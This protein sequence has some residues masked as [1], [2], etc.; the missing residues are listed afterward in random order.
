MAVIFRHRQQKLKSVKLKRY[1]CILLLKGGQGTPALS[2]IQSPTRAAVN[3]SV[4]MHSCTADTNVTSQHDPGV[5][6]SVSGPT[7]TSLIEEY[8]ATRNAP[9]ASGIRSHL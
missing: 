1:F 7:I 3:D 4:S 2:S 5:T 6:C 9:Q 8:I